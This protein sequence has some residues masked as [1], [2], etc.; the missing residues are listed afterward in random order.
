MP[1]THQDVFVLSDQV[2]KERGANAVQ[3]VDHHINK[4]RLEGDERSAVLWSMV[5]AELYHREQDL[6]A[7]S[8]IPSF[9]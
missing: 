1:I 5:L 3:F 4:L 8:S 6:S 7:D 9:F 2:I